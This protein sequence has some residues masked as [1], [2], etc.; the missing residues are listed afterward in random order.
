MRLR[1]LRQLVSIEQVLELRGLTETLTRRGHRLVG[2]C[3]VH[4][5]DNP[6]AFVAD[7]RRG[8]WNCHT[9]CRGGDVVELL[10]ALDQVSYAEVAQTL[11]AIAGQ[12]PPRPPTPPPPPAEPFRPYTRRLTLD[13]HHPFLA[14]RRI[15]PATAQRFEVGAWSGWGMLQGCVAVRLH[16]VE[17]RPLGYAGRRLQPDRR[18]KWVFP[19]R[20]P[21]SSLLYG[22]HRAAAHD[23][24]VVVEGPWEVLRLHQLGLPAVALLGTHFSR[25]Q[26]E[27]LARRRCLLLLD[28]DDA[29]RAAARRLA[30]ALTAPIVDLPIAR[31]PADLPD[32]ELVSLLRPSFSSNQP[33][34]RTVPP[35]RT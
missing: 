7:C 31:D 29:G 25:N 18:G 5:G 10:R 23:P 32:Q 28:G 11:R 8:L 24:L 34:L 14:A 17:G 22:W 20:L 26:V 19:R 30:R 15:H 27:L 2:P 33:D 13:P 16:D 12:L 35:A 3:P 6:T 4:G 9:V 21:K 1:E